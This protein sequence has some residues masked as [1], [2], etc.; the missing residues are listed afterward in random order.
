ML[1]ALRRLTVKRLIRWLKAFTLIEMLVVIAIIGI[2]AG[3]LLPALQRAREQARIA[4]CKGNIG[5]IGKAIY[6]YAEQN[7]EFYP[8]YEGP[9]STKL[10]D[11]QPAGDSLAMLYPDYI[12]ALPVFQCA[13]ATDNPTVTTTKS[14]NLITRRQFGA[15]RPEWASYGYD[16]KISFRTA[17][18]LQPIAA[19]MDG[20]SVA[21]PTSDFSN[22]KGG[23]N[24]LFYDTHVDWKSTNT[25]NN[26]EQTDN[27]YDID[28]YPRG[29]GNAKDRSNWAD[30]DVF[31]RR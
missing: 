26:R 4:K 14:G 23:Q 1:T 6:V 24:V 9:D 28:L 7:G 29:S 18:A 3:M 30:T 20:S 27:I 2:L 16:D 10:P 19:D 8:Y 25:W 21:D 5:Q 13:S 31:I 15:D 11:E 22:H 17:T 12:P